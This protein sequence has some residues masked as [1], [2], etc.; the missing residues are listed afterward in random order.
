MKIQLKEI[1]IIIIC[2]SLTGCNNVQNTVSD[3][4]DISENAETEVEEATEII[5]P[6]SLNQEEIDELVANLEGNWNSKDSYDAGAMKPTT[7][8]I[9]F[10]TEPFFIG[11]WHH[12]EDP[13]LDYKVEKDCEIVMGC[14]LWCD[15][16]YFYIDSVEKEDENVY[17]FYVTSLKDEDLAIRST[18]FMKAISISNIDLENGEMNIAYISNADNPNLDERSL[19]EIEYSHILFD[20]TATYSKR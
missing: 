1:L 4:A 14:N 12:D 19:E 15:S 17:T 7:L 3:N 6:Y 5:Y 10:N 11:S 16:Y 8:G 18:D 2:V 9:R 13:S 20:V